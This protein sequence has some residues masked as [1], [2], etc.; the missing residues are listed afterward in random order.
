MTQLKEG[1]LRVWNMVNMDSENS[2]IRRFPVPN[3]QTAAFLTDVLAKDQLTNDNVACNAFGLEVYEKGEW[4]E[5]E[6]EEGREL[7]DVQE[8]VLAYFLSLQYYPK[9]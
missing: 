8:S 7:R 6:D 4:V 1:D 5:W 3:V 2:E 9:S